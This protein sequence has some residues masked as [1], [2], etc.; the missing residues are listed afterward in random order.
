MSN[1]KQT[2]TNWNADTID[3]AAGTCETRSE[4]YDDFPGAYMAAKRLGI[5]EE[6]CSAMVKPKR[7]IW[8]DEKIR[9]LAED[10]PSLYYIRKNYPGAYQRIVEKGELKEY[11]GHLDRTRPPKKH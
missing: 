5:F 4:F 11:F 8:T 1:A 10:A 2:R 6:V 3:A 9:T 7:L